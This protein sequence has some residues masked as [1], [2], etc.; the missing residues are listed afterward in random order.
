LRLYDDVMKGK[1]LLINFFV[2]Q[3]DVVPPLATENLVR[4]QKLLGDRVGGEI[5]MI[6]ISLQPEH[7]TPEIMSA[8]AKTYGIGPGWLL[9]TGKPAYRTSASPAGFRRYRS[10]RGRQPGRAPGYCAN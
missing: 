5:R 1:I 10:S 9:L 7:D 2:A 3:P 4:L 8:Y 6:S